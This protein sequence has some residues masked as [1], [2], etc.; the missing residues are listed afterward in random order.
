MAQVDD[1]L[2]YALSARAGG[3]GQQW[4]GVGTAPVVTG[5]GSGVLTG[6]YQYAVTFATVDGSGNVLGECLP[7]PVGSVSLSAQQASV[8]SIPVSGSPAC[9]ARRI[10]RTVA[11]G[12]QLKFLHM[13]SDNTTT[14]YTDN[15]ADG[16]L[17]ANVPTKDT[18]DQSVFSSQNF[19][20][21]EFWGG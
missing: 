13:I 19:L 3:L 1:L 2:V 14:T 8:A 18:S 6:S 10:Y 16:T 11:G 15:A 9:N 21:H 20:W 17:G 12:S 4:L 5:T 7:T